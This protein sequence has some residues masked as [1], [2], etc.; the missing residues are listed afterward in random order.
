MATDV[1]APLPDETLAPGAT[2]TVTLD[3][4]SAVVTKLNV[5]GFTPAR[6]EP[7]QFDVLPPLLSYGAEQ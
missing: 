4:A 7:P 5:Y 6:V 2:I 3:D 1:A